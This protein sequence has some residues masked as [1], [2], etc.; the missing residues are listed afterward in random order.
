ML[1]NR[2]RLGNKDGIII[3]KGDGDGRFGLQEGESF[4]TWAIV[5]ESS[6]IKS[7]DPITYDDNGN[8]IPLSQRFRP[9]RED[10]RYARPERKEQVGGAEREESKIITTPKGILAMTSDALRQKV[11]NGTSVSQE[12]TMQAWTFIE[13]LMDTKGNNASD[14]AGEINDLVVAELTARREAEIAAGV[15]VDLEEDVK[16]RIGAAMFSVE[17]MNYAG[18]LAEQGDARMLKFMIRN[19]N[20]MPLDN[21]STNISEAARALRTRLEYEVS[22][23][24][25]Y[26]NDQKGKV[27]RTAADMFGTNRPDQ[28]Q[29]DAVKEALNESERTEFGNAEDVAEDIEKVEGRT[30]RKVIKKI[31]EKIKA[32][33]DPKVEELLISFQNLNQDRKISGVD[34]VYKPKKVDPAKNIQNLIIGKLVDYRKTLIKQGADGLESTFWQTMS[35]QERKPGPLGEI[36]KAQNNELAKIVQKTLIDLG[37]KGTPPNTKMSDIEKVASILNKQLLG[38]EKKIAADKRIVEEIERRREAALETSADPDAVNAKYDAILDAWN[39]AMSRQLNMPISDNMLQRLINAELKEQN[40]KI[41]ELVEQEDG[42]LVADTKKGIV[43]SIIKKLYRVSKEAETGVEIDEGYDAV[44]RYLEQTLANMY[45]LQLEKK[46]A[47]YARRLANRSLRNGPEAQAQSIINSLSDELSDTPAFPEKS[48][49][50]IKSIVKQ[51]LGQIPDINRKQPWTSQLT[52]RLIQAG[53][54]ESQAQTISDLVWRQHE[55]KHMDRQLKELKTAAEKGSIAVIVDRIKNTP[56]EKQQSA[57]WTQDVIRE[58]LRSAGLSSEAADSAAKLYESVIAERLAEAKQKVFEETINKSAPWK[59]FA[60][61]NGKLAQNALERVKVAIRAGVLDPETS[62][63]SIIAAQNGWTGFT[64]EQYQEIVRLDSIINDPNSDDL[65]KREA[66]SDLNKIIVKAKLPVKFRDA[67]GAYYV[68]NALMGIPTFT[69]NVASPLGFSARNLFTDIAKYA[70]TNPSKI[71]VAF[72]SFMDSMRSWYGNVSYSFKNEIFP[73]D[74]VEY[75]QGQNV[76]SELFDKGKAQWAKG[77]YANGMG[78][79]LVGMTKITGRVLSALDQG[80]IAMLEN[81]GLTRYAMEALSSQSS[82]PKDQI[83]GLGQAIISIRNKSIAQ[84]VANGMPKDRAIVLADLAARSELIYALSKEG[85]NPNDVLNAALNDAFQSVG[86]NRTL[87]TKGLEKSQDDLKDA[88]TFTRF[89]IQFLESISSL[90]AKSGPEM[91]VFSKMLYGFALVPARVFS[92]VAW[93]SP[94]GAYRLAVDAFSKKMGWKSP[95]AMSLQTDVQYAQRLT[96]TIAGSIVM[97]GLMSLRESSTEDED[98]TK[99]FRIVIT[100]NGPSAATDRQY[101]DS[102]HKKWKPYSIH[103]VM[104]D[105]IIPINIGRGGEALFFPIMMAGAMDDLDIKKKQNLTKK[106]PEDLVDAA[107]VLGSAFFALAQR[108]PY[109]AFTRPLFDASKQGRVTEELASQAAYFGKTFVP[110]LGSSLSRNISDFFS[111]PIDKSSLNG[112]IYANTPVIGPWMG[113]KALNGLGQPIRADDWGDKLFKLGV[114]VVFSFPKNTPENELNE[115]V[116][117]QGSGPTIPTRSNAQ[118]RVGDVITDKEF[119]IYVRE[120]GRIMSKKMFAN[121]AKLARMKPSDYDDELSK[122]ARGSSGSRGASESAALAVKRS[123]LYD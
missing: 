8:V 54:T 1:L 64:K 78:N 14:F 6:Q 80:S 79:M 65:T 107:E 59:N 27:D 103:I 114:P 97:L 74:V 10:I 56:L 72:Q 53:A 99:G 106:N 36:D 18:R 19:V 3:W 94:I 46:N 41:S 117:K 109:A 121:R 29:V 50:L 4:P 91:Q 105:T 13:R 93:F 88:G 52:A 5:F 48:E 84:S 40:V 35:D 102:W 37:L 90:A 30:G 119:E 9:E 20:S 83:N 100:G 45:D 25:A 86:R 31:E 85:V 28:K 81:Q 15:D 22:G 60:S 21:R 42:K 76:L 7:A 61:R 112:A 67:L 69:V 75:L 63:E 92:N 34:V 108:G 51:D 39:Q 66:M 11:F 23:F 38:E 58:Y 32:S 16:K 123:R 95:Y 122:Y 98:D 68:G 87:T 47:A 116:L 96:E 120:Y 44:K 110:V 12:N 17:L 2:L 71:P 70:V 26:T 49:N 55:I 111:D 77:E 101:Y 24:S 115:L 89:P 73:N 62:T 113:T 43:D 118:K 82:I 57:N 33:T 104:G